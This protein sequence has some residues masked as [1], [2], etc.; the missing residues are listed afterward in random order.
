M[1]ARSH[2]TAIHINAIGKSTDSLAF[3]AASITLTNNPHAS[4][5][6]SAC[7]TRRVGGDQKGSAFLELAWRRAS[8]NDPATATPAVPSHSPANAGGA[9]AWKYKAAAAAVTPSEPA[10]NMIGASARR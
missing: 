5:G 2:K 7:A 1:Q 3:N 9:S 8:R 10:T 4:G 6:E